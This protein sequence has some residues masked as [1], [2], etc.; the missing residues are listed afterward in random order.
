M[1]KRITKTYPDV[2]L[3]FLPPNNYQEVNLMLLDIIQGLLDTY[4]P[5]GDSK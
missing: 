1:G 5:K 4:A 2:E 3:K